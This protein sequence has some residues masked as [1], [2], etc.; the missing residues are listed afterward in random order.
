MVCAPGAPRSRGSGE[1]KRGSGWVGVVLAD[2]VDLSVGL[3]A[4]GGAVA[5]SACGAGEVVMRSGGVPVAC[6]R[7]A[8]GLS[9]GLCQEHRSASRKTGSLTWDFSARG[10]FDAFTCSSGLAD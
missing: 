8:Y 3:S 2:L 7:N 9:Y 1:H 4:E 5:G 10:C 6:R